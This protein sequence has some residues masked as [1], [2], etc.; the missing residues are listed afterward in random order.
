V[1]EPRERDGKKRKNKDKK[2]KEERRANLLGE[3]DDRYGRLEIGGRVFVRSGYSR[4][5]VG[6]TTQ[7]SLD[8]SI[9]SARLDFSYEAPAK[10]L[11]MDIEIELSGNPELK[12][13]YVQARDKGFFARAG[14]FK[15]PVSAMEMESTW[16]LPLA[17]RGF[18]H[19]LLLD[20]LDVAGRR[21]GV[22]VGYRAKGGIKPRLTLGVFQGSVLQDGNVT[23]GDRDVVLIEE[24]DLSAQGFAGRFDVDLGGLELGAFYQHRVGSPVFP[25]TEHYPLGGVDVLFDRTF[26][27]GGL[28]VWA[29][30]M[31]GTSW[32]EFEDKPADDDDAVFVEGRVLAAYRFGGTVDE[33]FYVEPFGMLGMLEPDTD[34]D[35]DWALEA[36]LGLNVGLWRRARITLQGELN[37]GDAKFPNQT[38][39]YLYGLSPDKLGLILQAGM[40]F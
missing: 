7:S 6:A 34:V 24:K 3:D 1:L 10:W 14:Q 37:Q 4:R 40:A 31:A 13:A 15:P 17:H 18:I 19:D 36:V 25:E 30:A 11:S 38:T 8:L 33:A 21:P 39:G 28:R 26:E 9:P 16:A 27:S 23:P 2:K 29:D 32:Y 22:I 20:Y 12:D 35:S 5:D